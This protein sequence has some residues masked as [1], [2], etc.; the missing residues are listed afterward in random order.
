MAENWPIITDAGDY[1]GQ[2]KKKVSLEQRRPQIRKASDLVGP[3]I[4]ATAVRITDFN[5][6]LATYNG[7]FSAKAGAL[8]A[9]NGTHDFVGYTVAD[10]EFGGMQVFRSMTSAAQFVRMMRRNP[11][12]PEFITWSSWVAGA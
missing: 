7:F 8:N 3:G 12:D 6:T 2:E 10:S 4:A 5:D 9:P 1:F 11:G